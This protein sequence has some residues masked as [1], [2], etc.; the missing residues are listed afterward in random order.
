M[1][2]L[3]RPANLDDEAEAQALL[4]TKRPAMTA[5]REVETDLRRYALL[6]LSAA[7][8]RREGRVQHALDCERAMESLYKGL[9]EGWRW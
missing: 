7:K 4:R 2:L 5:P 8:A 6:R 1:S 9:P 3:D